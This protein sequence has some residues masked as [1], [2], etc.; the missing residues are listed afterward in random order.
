[1]VNEEKNYAGKWKKEEKLG[2]TYRRKKRE[3]MK[4]KGGVVSHRITA[5]FISLARRVDLVV[6]PRRI[7]THKSRKNLKGEETV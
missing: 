3:T 7:W 5:H 1:V 6:V 4:I 2:N